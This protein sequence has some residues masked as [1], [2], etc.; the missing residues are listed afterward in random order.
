MRGNANGT[1]YLRSKDSSAHANRLVI[2]RMN[3]HVD[4]AGGVDVHSK[5]L[6][7]SI[8]AGDEYITRS[9]KATKNG[10]EELKEWLAENDCGRVLFEATGVY[11]YQLYLALYL[12]LEVVV[13]NPW[14][15]KNI[16][17]IKTDKRDS[18]WLAK[19]CQQ[20]LANP[21][22]VFT[23][24]YY[25]YRELS[26]HREA[27]VKTRTTL[28][29]R[30]HRRLELCNIKL[31]QV[32]TD[33]FGKNGRHVLDDLLKGR[34]LEEIFEDKKLRLSQAKKESLRE[35][36]A[37]SL[38]P[39]SIRTIEYHLKM[40]DDLDE[41]VRVIEAEMARKGREKKELL[42]ILAGVPGV[43]RVGAHTILAEIGQ[44]EDFDNGEQLASYFGLV[45]RIYQSGEK[46]L[47]GHI[48]KHGSPHMR[49]IL[50][51]IAHTLGRM[52]ENNLSRFYNRLRE[53]KGAGV[54]AV[55]TARKLLC[56]IHH[57]LINKEPYME[58][59]GKKKRIRRLP[60]IELRSDLE[61]ALQVVVQA[62][63]VVKQKGRTT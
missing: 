23:G 4:K 46:N 18:Q 63:Y 26:R 59:D 6:V 13:A 2:Y 57:L 35:A 27:L 8:V 50:V 60:T 49:W 56:I 25:E 58:E 45:P 16:H 28:K 24:W 41:E 43:G 5:T 39:L 19:V 29:N 17:G 12:T 20:K 33:C 44:V 1:L 51:Q 9:F 61:H 42:D 3:D 7:A 22:R 32:F 55:A 48:T 21:S 14:H 52:K 40:I 10:Y 15:I 54:A 53:R 38:D 34:P 47:T 30:V 37:D 62:G 11:W 36:V 31:G